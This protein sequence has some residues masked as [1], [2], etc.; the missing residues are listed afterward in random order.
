[1]DKTKTYR[2]YTGL[3]EDSD[4]RSSLSTV[5]IITDLKTTRKKEINMLI[6]LDIHEMGY[7]CK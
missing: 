1:M 6:T 5:S 2:K 3:F 4:N 7:I